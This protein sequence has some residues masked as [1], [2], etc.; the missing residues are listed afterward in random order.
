MLRLIWTEKQ[1]TTPGWYWTRAIGQRAKYWR[2]EEHIV[3]IREYG[4]KLCIQNWRIA[5]RDTEWAGPIPEPKN[6]HQ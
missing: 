5:D 3:Y 2:S 1:P 6:P 4:G